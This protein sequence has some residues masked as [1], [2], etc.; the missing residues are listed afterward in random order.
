MFSVNVIERERKV[1]ERGWSDGDG[2]EGEKKD[3]RRHGEAER[4]RPQRCESK[5][6]RKSRQPRSQT[7][8]LCAK[9]EGRVRTIGSFVRLPRPIFC[10]PFLENCSDRPLKYTHVWDLRMMHPVL[11]NENEVNIRIPNYKES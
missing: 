2:I 8:K 9:R 6:R 7:V 3:V 10:H 5:E 11:R 4:N 1:S